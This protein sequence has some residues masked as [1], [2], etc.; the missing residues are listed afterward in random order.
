MA[1][2]RDFKQVDDDMLIVNGDFV[3]DDSDEQHIEDLLM[4]GIGSYKEFP[5]STISLNL[6]LNSPNRRNDIE[7]QIQ[8]ILQGDGYQVDSSK[9]SFDSSG[10]LIAPVIAIKV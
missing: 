1:T 8:I 7:K 4:S 5:N 2:S 10:K 3:I 9:F 6:F